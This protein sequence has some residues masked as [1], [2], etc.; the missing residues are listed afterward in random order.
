[1]KVQTRNSRETIARET[2]VSESTKEKVFQWLAEHNYEK[3]HGKI[4]HL[5]RDLGLDYEKE[6]RYLWFLSSQF[7]TLAIFRQGL[8]CPTFHNW[9]GFAYAPLAVDRE[10]A[11]ESGWVLSRARNRMF[12]FRD[13]LGRL[14]WFETGRI[15]VW[16]KKPANPGK[17]KQLLANAFLWSKLISDINDFEAYAATVRLWGAHA[18]YDVGERLPYVRIDDFR[19]SNGITVKV[20]DLSHPRAVEIEFHRLKQAEELRETTEA[21]IDVFRVNG[22]GDSRPG[23][24]IGVV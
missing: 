17:L 10:A 13:K 3:K 14:E 18:V 12:V 7:K 23:K 15:N 19:E 5:C 1:M 16:L 20:G 8:K 21:F 22:S 4:H 11:L 2:R 24:N 9:R 6:K